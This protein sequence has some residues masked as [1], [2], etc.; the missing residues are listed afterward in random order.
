MPK[1]WVKL[2][3]RGLAQTRTRHDRAALLDTLD[4]LLLIGAYGIDDVIGES[5]RRQ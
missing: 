1:K 2:V 4:E 5:E 3:I